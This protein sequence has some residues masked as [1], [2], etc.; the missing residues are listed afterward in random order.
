MDNAPSASPDAVGDHALY[1]VAD[2]STETLSQQVWLNPGLYTIGF[3]TYVPFNGYDNSG[4]ATFTGTIAGVTLANF[5]AHASVPGQWMSYAGVADI[6][7]AGWYTAE[8]TYNSGAAPAADFLVDRAYIVAGNVVPEPTTWA[9]MIM[10]FGGA[11]AL[12][13]QRRRQAVAA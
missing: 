2:A 7:T 6:A 8:F 11:G 4:D 3:D 5:S 10:G 13:R 9:L 12:L 1:F